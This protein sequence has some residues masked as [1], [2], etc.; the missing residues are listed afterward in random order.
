MSPLY[1]IITLDLIM[2]RI[3][4]KRKKWVPLTVT[5]T[6]IETLDHTDEIILLLEMED[7]EG[8]T[9]YITR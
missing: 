5:V 2:K 9:K 3:D 6:L 7:S 4:V 8:I 1:L